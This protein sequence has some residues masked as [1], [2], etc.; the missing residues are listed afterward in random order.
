MCGQSLKTLFFIFEKS[1]WENY[2]LKKLFFYFQSYNYK[3][4]HENSPCF[5]NPFICLKHSRKA[6]GQVVFFASKVC[7]PY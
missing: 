1:P 3:K 4:F 2:L 5:K 6:C 7:F